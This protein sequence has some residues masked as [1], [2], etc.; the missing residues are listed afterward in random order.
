MKTTYMPIN[1]WIDKED[2]VNIHNGILLGHLKK[3]EI[4]CICSNMNGLGK[5]YAK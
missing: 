4:L 3:N 2:V 5:H 1:R